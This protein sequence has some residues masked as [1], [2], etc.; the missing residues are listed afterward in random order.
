MGVNLRGGFATDAGIVD[1]INQDSILLR[2]IEQ[3]GNWFAAGVVCDGIGGLEKGEVVSKLVTDS[4]DKWFQGICQWIRI[5]TIDPNAMLT[6]ATEAAKQWNTI[7][8]QFCDSS[9]VKGGTTMSLIVIIKGYYY[10]IH[11]GD[12]RI[13]C[14]NQY[15]QQLTED[16]VTT[17]IVDGKSKD[18]L[19]NFLGKSPDLRYKT[20]MGE[21]K[22]GDIFIFCS[23]GFYR[24]LNPE[25]INPCITKYRSGMAVYRICEDAINLMKMRQEK[26]N[27]SV[28]MIFT[29]HTKSGLFK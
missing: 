15:L 6:H 7:V 29:E 26:D 5:D 20:Y 13:Y 9:N 4:F 22:N 18:L 24:M 19:N 3:N 11:V 25:D 12:S 10:I 16:D 1:T 28:G 17:K 14:C 21:I 8:C 27:I 23:D 2:A